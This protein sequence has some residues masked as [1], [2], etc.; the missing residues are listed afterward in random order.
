ML[1][2]SDTELRRYIPNVLNTVD[3]EPSLYDKLQPFLE[4]AERWVAATFTGQN[5]LTE[6]GKLSD[7]DPW[8]KLICS[9]I[10]NH[11]FFHVVPSLDL[12]L[13][14]NGFGIVN[15]SNVAPASKERVERLVASLEE[16]RDNYIDTLLRSL[17][18]LSVGSE[19]WLDTPQSKFFAATLFPDFTACEKTATTLHRWSQYLS[20][21]QQLMTIEADLSEEYFS[22]DEMTDF[23]YDVLTQFKDTAYNRQITIQSIRTLEIEVLLGRTPHP[24]RFRDVVNYIRE[25][26]ENFPKW[27][28]SNTAKLYEPTIFSNKKRSGGFWF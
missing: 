16:Q 1:I 2:Q 25:H 15:N 23:R 14:P 8:H 13:T 6:I 27:H 4:A 3:G 10:A 12:I 18:S 21:R 20:L 11:T 24:Q 9:L 22:P 5:L 7:S 17:P 26:P 19:T 28:K